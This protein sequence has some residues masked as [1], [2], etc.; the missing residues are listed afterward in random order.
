MASSQSQNKSNSQLKYLGFI[1]ILIVHAVGLVSNLYN[2]VKMCCSLK[3]TID[4]VENAVTAV[5]GPV[6]EKIKDGP[7]DLLV[8]FDNKVDA[9]AQKLDELTPPAVKAIA[10]TATQLAGKAS[11]VA[12]DLA[13]EAKAGGPL[14]AIAQAGKISKDIAIGQLAAVAHKAN[15]QPALQGLAEMAIPA[16]ANLSNKYNNLVKDMAGKGFQM[17]KYVPLVP[18]DEVADA[19]KQVESGTGASPDNGSGNA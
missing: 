16:A 9:A 19:Y 6:F 18:V 14:A 3:S 2:V 5:V 7:G 10:G 12:L 17:F 4:M 13:G 11:K 8:F 15:Q 1:R